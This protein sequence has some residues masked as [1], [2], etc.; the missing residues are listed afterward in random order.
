MGLSAALALTPALQWSERDPAREAAALETL[1]LWALQFTAAVALKPPGTLLLETGGSV[2]LFGGLPALLGQITQDLEAQGF[3]AVL[4]SAP[5]PGGALMLAR[6][7]FTEHLQTPA[8]LRATLPGL[9]ALALE[10]AAGCAAT[11]ENLGL[12]TLADVLA[13]PRDGLARRFGTHLC[14]ELDRALGH[15][16]DPVRTI[17][18]PAVFH[19]VIALPAPAESAEAI[20]FACQRAFRQLEGF[21]RAGRKAVD[22][23]DLHLHHERSTRRDKLN[24]DAMIALDFFEPAI[25][26]A[27]F[28]LILR[29]RLARTT[30]EHRVERITLAAPQLLDAVET[31]AA[32]LPAAPRPGRGLATLLERLH[33]RLGQGT[34]CGLEVRADHRP[35]RATALPPL[36]DGNAPQTP[37]PA[38]PA[39]RRAKAT[40]PAAT[41]GPR[42]VWFTEP[43]KPLREVNGKPHHEGPLTLVAGPERIESGWWDGAPVMRDYFIAQTEARAL[44]WIFRERREPLGWF[45]QGW[46]G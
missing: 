38:G 41:F 13:L 4:A 35:A 20:L 39:P 19:T 8:A 15:R 2:M 28:S 1:G 42:P 40:P 18:P 14:E 5:T 37:R 22:H 7:G 33:A 10:G 36:I 29:E 43:P 44:V 32:L 21:L 24:T 12:R 16:P 46:F 45:L 30:L 6:S 27:R 31:T 26:A 3:A 17:V 25:T 9:P 34:I 11:F 23:L